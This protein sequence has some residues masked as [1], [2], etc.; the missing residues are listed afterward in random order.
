MTDNQRRALKVWQVLIACASQRQTITYG[1]LAELID[2]PGIGPN[3]LTPYLDRV[4]K[5]SVK[6][7]EPPGN[8][9]TVVVVNAETGRPGIEVPE[10]DEEREFVYN[11]KWFAL[12]PPAPE[13]FL[14]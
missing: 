12:T 11:V 14:A 2:E 6:S 3:L 8:D 5:F 9:L 10:W 4:R 1:D 13:D 7:T